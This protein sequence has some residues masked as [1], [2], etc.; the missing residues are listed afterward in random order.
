MNSV[1]LINRLCRWIL[2]ILL[3][4]FISTGLSM[5]GYF[6]MNRIIPVATAISIHNNLAFLSLLVIFLF[7]HCCFNRI[8]ILIR[9]LRKTK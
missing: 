6:G 1:Y 8:Y 5:T 3:L 2:L 7:L 4:V 9:K